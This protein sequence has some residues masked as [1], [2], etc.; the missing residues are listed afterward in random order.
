[1][2]TLIKKSLVLVII[3]TSMVSYSNELGITSDNKNANVT[4]FT[5]NDV[6]EGS[7]LYI[8]DSDGSILYN[9]TI[10]KSG[11]FS[12]NF[13]LTNLPDA[14]YYFE[15]D[16]QK[17][18]TIIPVTVFANMAS[19]Q[20]NEA[21]TITKPDVVLDNNYVYISKELADKQSVAIDVYYEGHDLAYSENLRHA[22][23]VN[24]VYDFSGSKKGEYVILVKSEGRVFKN[25]III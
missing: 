11:T 24:R 17:Q 1:M 14:N 21:Y 2:K 7:T 19:V 8:K 25:S 5:L 4:E 18:I 23:K 9:E 6:K 3:L 12:K 16:Y 15:V 13:D 20:V 10:G 22:E